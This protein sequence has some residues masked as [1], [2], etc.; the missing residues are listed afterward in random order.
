MKSVCVF[1]GSS[2]GA[3]PV[4]PEAAAHL[5]RAV[6]GRGLTLVYG[7]GHVG[8][9]GVAADAA[10]AA[11]GRVVGVIPEA[12]EAKELAHRGLTELRVVGSMHERKALMS[13][14]A[15]GFIALPGGVGT[16]EEWFEVWTW[17][18]LGIQRKPCGLLNV[19]GYYDHLL[20]FLDHVTAE[21]FLAPD[22]RAMVLV[23]DDDAR[24]LDRLAG[25]RHPY[26]EKWLDRSER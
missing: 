21:R 9:M 10:L 15:D 11:G 13:E 14:L 19:A 18:Q 17:S 7:G 3:S 20:A 4:Y 16:L 1:C 8:L 24:L 25:Y 26:T 5:G 2:P 6:A 23:D 12:L 22:H